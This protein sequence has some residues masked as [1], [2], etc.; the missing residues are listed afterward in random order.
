VVSDYAWFLPVAVLAERR[1][2]RFEVVSPEP[3]KT[4][5]KAADIAARKVR[6]R[7]G[8]ASLFAPCKNVIGMHLRIF[9]FVA[10]HAMKWEHF[11]VY[12]VV[13]AAYFFP[14]R[15]L[16]LAARRS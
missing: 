14:W 8:G 10:A 13:Y 15:L 12:A 9:F 16:S 11:A 5:V 1:H 4:S 7:F 6:Q 2:F 3:P